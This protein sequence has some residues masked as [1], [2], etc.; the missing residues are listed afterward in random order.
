MWEE[1]NSKEMYHTCVKR[2]EPKYIMLSIVV[3]KIKHNSN[4]SRGKVNKVKAFNGPIL[5][6]RVKL[7]TLDLIM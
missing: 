4:L 2:N 5:T 6:R 3:K 1:T 7:W